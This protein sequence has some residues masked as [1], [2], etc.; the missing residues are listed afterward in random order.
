MACE[1]LP[2]SLFLTGFV[3]YR[4]QTAELPADKR[5]NENITSQI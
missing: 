5:S 4:H 3:N 2:A 1:T